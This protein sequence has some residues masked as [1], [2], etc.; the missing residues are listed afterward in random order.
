[1]YRL[2][3]GKYPYEAK[4]LAGMT[5][6]VLNDAPVPILRRDPLLPRDFVEI[7]ERCLERSPAKRFSNAGQLRQALSSL[8]PNARRPEAAPVAAP[9]TAPEGL[10]KT[11]R[12]PDADALPEL[13]PEALLRITGMGKLVPRAEVARPDVVQPPVVAEPALVAERPD[14][15]EPPIVARP[16]IVTQSASAAPNLTEA[17]VAPDVGARDP[18][19]ARFLDAKPAES[20]AAF[21]APKRI[22]VTHSRVQVRRSPREPEGPGAFLAIILPIGLALALT[23]LFWWWFF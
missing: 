4:S 17:S 22:E 12:M 5:M 6:A 18:E 8:L 10:P 14:L 15:A 3:T 19:F 16:P 2:A 9:P 7:V 1:M 23:I 21:E 20:P 13:P 11:V